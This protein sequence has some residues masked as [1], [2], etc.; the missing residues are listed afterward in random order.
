M[1]TVIAKCRHCLDLDAVSYP[2]STCLFFYISKILGSVTK[3]C[4]LLEYIDLHAVSR[5][6]DPLYAELISLSCL[7]CL[8]SVFIHMRVDRQGQGMTPEESEDL[9]VSLDAIV[10]QG[11]LEVVFF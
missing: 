9:R 4:P 1:F 10:D 11:L 6:E 2:F 3:G 7:R 8:R 5:G